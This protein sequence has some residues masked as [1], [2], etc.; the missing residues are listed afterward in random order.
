MPEN[1]GKMARYKILAAA[2][3]NR[4]QFYCDVSGAL[5]CTTEPIFLPDPEQEAQ[6]AWESDGRKCFSLC[7][8][9]GRW[10]S[11]AVYNVDTLECVEC[12]PWEEEPSYC[13]HCGTLVRGAE[14]FCLKCGGRLRYGGRD[15]GGRTKSSRNAG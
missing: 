10:V 3:G 8:R 9:C 15:E 1:A 11:D 12:S 4:Y 13:P 6:F 5:V 2:D 14:V 7:H